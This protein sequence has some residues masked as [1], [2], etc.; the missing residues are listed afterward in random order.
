MRDNYMNSGIMALRPGKHTFD[1]LVA[2][3]NERKF[4]PV[5]S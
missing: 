4:T 5:G 2:E 1:A 3:F